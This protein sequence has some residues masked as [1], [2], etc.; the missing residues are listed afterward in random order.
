MKIFKLELKRAIFNKWTLFSFLAAFIICLIPI[1][2]KYE[3]MNALYDEQLV[4]G[5]DSIIC[6]NTVFHN[7]LLHD[8]SDI[9]LYIF[10]FIM[11]LLAALPYGVSYYNDI[12]CGYNKQ[13]VSRCHFRTYVT[14]KYFATFI[15]GGTVIVL[16]LVIQFMILMLIYPLDK[17]LRFASLM[18]GET[19]FSID[20]FY[21]HPLLQ[22]ILWCAIIFVVAGLLA[23]LSLAVSRMVY[24]YF[25]II[26]TPFVFSF[27][28]IFL[29]YVTEKSEL[30]FIYTLS[31][32]CLYNMNYG[33]LF[34]EIIA[35][36]IASFIPFVYQKK[37][38]L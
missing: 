26:L 29:T 15:S 27:I 17:P 28:L 34:T 30:A 14:A 11:P 32:N 3:N 9:L 25:G 22:A 4:E 37:E 1:P 5:S 33:V 10:M 38:V 12:K 8:R 2:Q 21:E 23:T 20:L 31:T 35:M 16:P 19:T 36:F 24:N 6:I 13:I 18:I 7:W